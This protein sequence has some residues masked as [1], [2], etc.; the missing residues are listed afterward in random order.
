MSSE[1]KQAGI[2]DFEDKIKKAG[3][4]RIFSVISTDEVNIIAASFFKFISLFPHFKK[5][6]SISKLKML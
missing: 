6:M 5:G 1:E 2:K 4:S 3:R